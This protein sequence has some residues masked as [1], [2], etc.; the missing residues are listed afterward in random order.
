LVPE[1]RLHDRLKKRLD[2]ERADS[3]ETIL[4]LALGGDSTVQ[5]SGTRSEGGRCSITAKES[6]G[7]RFTES[8][9]G[10]AE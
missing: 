10:L 2:F 8:Q 6:D 4:G 3:M 7:T 1:L 9:T 5:L